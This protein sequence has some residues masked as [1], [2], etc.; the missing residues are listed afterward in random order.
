M[1]TVAAQQGFKCA[2]M[3]SM[4]AA[5]QFICDLRRLPRW[6]MPRNDPTRHLH[7]A[8]RLFI[9][10]ASWDISFVLLL[11]TRISLSLSAKPRMSLR[12]SDN[13]L[14]VSKKEDWDVKRK[15]IAIIS[16]T[17]R[18]P[19][20]FASLEL[21]QST[22]VI[23]VVVNRCLAAFIQNNSKRFSLILLKLCCCCC[24]MSIFFT[25]RFS[26]LSLTR[27]P[28]MPARAHNSF[29][30]EMLP[31]SNNGSGKSRGNKRQQAA[32]RS[33]IFIYALFSFST[34]SS[35]V[36]AARKWIVN[37]TLALITSII[38]RFFIFY[39]KPPM[40][41]AKMATSHVKHS[42]NPPRKK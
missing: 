7:T 39:L 38:F 1:L 13:V 17:I 37:A 22:Q 27:P 21:L 3:L 10:G 5:Q 36:V 31:R 12:I 6:K 28:P 4:I 18:F 29:L 26:P 20:S 23:V 25:I 16:L 19:S 11:A 41:W 9:N 14:R 8:G 15:L 32:W 33:S 35:S 34:L 40:S 30:N 42:R 24:S 2:Q